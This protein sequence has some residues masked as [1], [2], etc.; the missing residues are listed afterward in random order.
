MA[1]KLLSNRVAVR[2]DA[3]DEVSAGGI[4]LAKPASRLRGT[5][6]AVGPGWYTARG[7]F[8]PTVVQV[9]D[10]VAYIKQAQ[11]QKE[12]LDGEEL[13]IMSEEQIIAIVED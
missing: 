2:A 13:L 9:G 11:I 7:D 12:K 6:V 3:N 10:R 5:V 8:V 1:F 4:H